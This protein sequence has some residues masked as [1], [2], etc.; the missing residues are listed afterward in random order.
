M[1]SQNNLVWIDLE[2]SGLE[3]ETDTILEIATIVTD[4]QLEIIEEGP[5]LVISQPDEVLDGMDEWNTRHHGDSGLTEAVRESDISM[6]QAQRETL[7]FIAKHCHRD[8]APLCGNSVW[9]D[10]RFLAKYMPRLE[11]YLHYRIIDV[12]SIKEVVRR[13]YPDEVSPP[14]KQQSHRAL[15]DIRESIRELKF[16]RSHVFVPPGG[17]ADIDAGEE[18]ENDGNSG[19]DQE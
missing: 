18:E 3:V 4:S 9:Q 1:P 10:R 2:M 15:D 11:Q 5:E 12:S 6:K 8:T 16:Y 17:R 19:D 7:K 14:S 13:W